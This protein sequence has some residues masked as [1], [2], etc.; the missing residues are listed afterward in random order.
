MS[1]HGEYSGASI[2]AVGRS[3]EDAENQP[4]VGTGIWAI[5][6]AE[7]SRYNPA[8]IPALS[9]AFLHVFEDHLHLHFYF[10]NH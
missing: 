6:G 5:I 7:V 2:V 3:G 4:T 10:R 1:S 9:D 8:T